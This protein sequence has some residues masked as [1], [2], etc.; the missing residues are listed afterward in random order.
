VAPSTQLE[1]KR[2]DRT[3]A[4][5]WQC[6]CHGLIRATESPVVGNG[7]IAKLRQ[8]KLAI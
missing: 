8:Q 6:F 3:Q 7:K 1:K 5:K 4:N 2:I